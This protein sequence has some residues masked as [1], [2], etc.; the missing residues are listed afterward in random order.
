MAR[1]PASHGDDNAHHTIADEYEVKLQ[2]L[3]VTACCQLR[4]LPQDTARLL[5]QPLQLG[6]IPSAL[7]H[8]LD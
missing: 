7:E 3:N 4:A 8:T 6:C 1:L 5:P 2:W